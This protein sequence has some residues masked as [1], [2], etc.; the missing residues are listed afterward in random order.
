MNWKKLT[1][2]LIASGLTQVEIANR[3]GCSQPTIAQLASGAQR[4][5]RWTYGEK[6][7]SLHRKVV[8]RRKPELAEQQEAA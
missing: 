7:R 2:D 1:Q 8:A 6:L 4:D 3:V 5:V